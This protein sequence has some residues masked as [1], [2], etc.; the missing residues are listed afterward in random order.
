M[1]RRAIFIYSFNEEDK[2]ENE[3]G[4]SNGGRQEREAC[5]NLEG[6]DLGLTS[7]LRGHFNAFARA[8]RL[9][10]RETLIGLFADFGV[11]TF[12]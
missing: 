10:Q 3:K 6:S 1:Q 12:N 11:V 9:T 7:L 5:R 4:E 8:P 2:R